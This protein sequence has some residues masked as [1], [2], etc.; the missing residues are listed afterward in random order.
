MSL[1]ESINL[2]VSPEHRE[3]IRQAARA[4]KRRDSEFIRI[5]AVE[6]A[7]FILKEKEEREKKDN[8]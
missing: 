3:I 2:R 5:A 6:A 7:H 4:I 1:T 8:E